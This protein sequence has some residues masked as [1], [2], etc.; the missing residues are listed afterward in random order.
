MIN[1][2]KF[3]IQMQYSRLFAR[4]SKSEGL[5]LAAKS[6]SLLVRAGYVRESVAGRYYFLPLGQRLQLKLMEVVRREMDK[7]GAQEILAPIL[8][9]LELW[10]ETNRDS[11]VGFELMQLKDRR[12]AG[13]ALGGT[14]E[15]MMVDLVR[16]FNLSYRDLP[17]NIYQFGMKFRDEL[18]ARGGLLRAREF[19]MKD[20][21]SFSTEEQF[22]EVYEA[23]RRAYLAIFDAIGLKVKVVDADNGY[24]GGE[25]C[26]EF[27]ADAEVGE[28]LYF[29]SDNGGRV[30]E[31]IA[32]F[33][34]G[35]PPAEAEK[36]LEA[37]A[38]ERG[39]TMADG[40]A[41]HAPAGIGRRSKNVAYLSEDGR[42]VLACLR[43]DLDVNEIKLKKVLGCHQL[44][45]LTEEQIAGWLGSAAGFISAVGLKLE[46]PGHELVVV[47][48]D[49]LEGLK[50]AISGANEAGRDYVN[51]NFGRDFNAD[52]V[53]DIALAKDGY[54]AVGGGR[55]RALK[56]IE[57]GNTFQLGYHYS[58]KMNG[59]EYAGPD[60]KPAKYYMGCY[61]IGIGRTMA[62][63]AE[64][65]SDDKGLVW[66]VC[67]TPYH[68]YLVDLT[69][70]EDGT[71]ILGR[72]REALA[73]AGLEVM[74]DDRPGVSPGEK[75]TNADLLGF[76][77]RLV[78]SRK[79][80]AAGGAEVKSR[81]S[82]ET[83][84]VEPDA[85]AG[86]CRRLLDSQ[87]AS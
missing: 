56:G 51:I 41:C 55:L 52:H 1:R 13:F 48:D 83:E 21:Y 4:S 37:V 43:G 69:T 11:S 20:A 77:I 62:A 25:Y 85:L 78:I 35:V 58:D 34:K 76:P 82:A 53:A 33:D 3:Q 22:E 36:P 26:H 29:E 57:V 14:A 73:A 12:G 70:G 50:N 47:A 7:A 46:K 32:V 5:N 39:P 79:T 49:S 54:P 74:A 64:I 18:R 27:I 75:L 45:P 8:H 81:R 9:P 38:V 68:V 2:S 10:Q 67:L 17:F 44:T 16:K 72:T 61:G 59:A 42:V 28:S 87:D 31:D 71:D 30:H 80:V 86:Y 63:L 65:N 84:I 23:M 66:P 19:I 24:I 6:H 60:G 15:E 40:L